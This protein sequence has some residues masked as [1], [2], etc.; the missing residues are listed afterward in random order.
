MSQ[1]ETAGSGPSVFRDLCHQ[2][3]DLSEVPPRLACCESKSGHTTGDKVTFWNSRKHLQLEA[4]ETPGPM[5][6]K[7]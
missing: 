5:V 3:E 1:I 6:S 4:H 2:P 7:P